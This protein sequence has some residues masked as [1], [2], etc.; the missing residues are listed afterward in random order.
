L[1]SGDTFSNHESLGVA[2]LD[3]KFEAVSGNLFDL[4]LAA[5]M[6]QLHVGHEDTFS[7]AFIRNSG[8]NNEFHPMD[9]PPPAVRNEDG[10]SE[11]H[12]PDLDC[13]PPAAVRNEHGES[14]F[15]PTDLDRKPSPAVRNEDD[16]KIDT[17][18]PTRIPIAAGMG[19]LSDSSDE[20]FAITKGSGLFQ[21]VLKSNNKKPK[22][23]SESSEEN[24]PKKRKPKKRKRQLVIDLLSDGD[25]DDANLDSQ[26][27]RTPPRPSRV[28][29]SP[30]FHFRHQE[31]EQ[32]S[33]VLPTEE[34]NY[35]PI[36]NPSDNLPGD[37]GSS[38][39][40]EQM[41]ERNDNRNDH[42]SE[43]QPGDVGSSVEPEQTERQL[44]NRNDPPSEN[45][46]GDVGSPAEPGPMEGANWMRWI[47]P[48]QEIELDEEGSCL[49]SLPTRLKTGDP[50]NGISGR[51]EADMDSACVHSSSLDDV[52]FSVTPPGSTLVTPSI[53][54]RTNIATKSR[55]RYL[56]NG[57]EIRPLFKG[58]PSPQTP[59][60]W[61]P[62]MRIAT[63]QSP[64]PGITF[65][66]SLFLIQDERIASSYLSEYDAAT[67]NCAMNTATLVPGRFPFFCSLT[68]SERESYERCVSCSV[69]HEM[70]S[71]SAVNH[72]SLSCTTNSF[73]GHNGY[74][75]LRLTHEALVDMAQPPDIWAFPYER[76]AIHWLTIPDEL[77]DKELHNSA[78]NI[79]CRGFFS[80]QAVGFKDHWQK[81]VIESNVP[82]H[83]PQRVEGF[84][85]RAFQEVL[86]AGKSLFRP[87][88]TCDKNFFTFDIATNVYSEKR[89]H[90]FSCNASVASKLAKHLME[91][92]QETASNNAHLLA[93]ANTNSEDANVGLDSTQPP[94]G[95]A[96]SQA[97]AEPPSD[98][99]S[100]RLSTQTL[101]VNAPSQANS[102]FDSDDDDDSSVL[103]TTQPGNG[104]YDPL[105]PTGTNRTSPLLHE[106]V[107]WV[108]CVLL[109]DVLIF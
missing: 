15:H 84:C 94:T 89:G 2:N 105:S 40:P 87:K 95:V 43:N 62:N 82:L 29:N 33:Q 74:V 47:A 5:E 30:P 38:V 31:E 104:M 9:L 54:N 102:V 90:S 59:L 50:A 71:G 57:D 39:E 23:S 34:R 68:H 60:H 3:G 53:L 65:N 86:E 1:S 80:A 6:S 16:G 103:D 25:C 69:P 37:V 58:K 78:R 48:R 32:H 85:V 109:F 10:E 100:P 36:D 91:M 108:D 4:A 99:D 67:M 66:L 28:S 61:C 96:V 21:C 11:F 51:L 13:K 64:I 45:H 106:N 88:R 92:T 101:T 49:I 79:L 77:D 41:E 12:P 24:K 81:K 26:R 19:N 52:A 107:I 22:R 27:D 72:A 63:I 7:E 73:P 35:N 44:D 56:R 76:K 42:P 98:D 17:P 70:R 8:I 46:Q 93:S 55:L 20:D 83:M 75:F 14:E 18:D 97:N